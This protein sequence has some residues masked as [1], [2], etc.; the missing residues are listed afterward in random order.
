MIKNILKLLKLKHHIKNI[1]VLIPLIFSMKLLELNSL[2]LALLAVIDFSII[3]SAVYV[4]ND[5]LDYENDKLHPIKRNRP[6]ASGVIKIPLAK[7]IFIILTFLSILLAFCI[8]KYVVICICLYL[9]LNIFYSIRLKFIPIIDVV[10]IALGFI[11]RILAGCAAIFVIPSPL[12][13][14]LTFFSSMFFTFSKRKLEYQLITEKDS[15]RKSIIEY[16]EPL[17]NQY[18]TIN[19]ILSISFYFTYILDPLTIEKTQAPLLYLTVIPFSIIVFRLLFK[20]FTC[21][22]NDDPAEFIYKDSMI[23]YASITYLITLAL[24]LFI[25]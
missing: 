7:L 16:N 12:V 17:L 10:C 25:F 14:L 19:A 3:A 20:T 1:V 18:V 6:I 5:I 2:I 13:I 23:I 24:V 21:K 8:N 22:N 9:V 15:C 4:F 11:L